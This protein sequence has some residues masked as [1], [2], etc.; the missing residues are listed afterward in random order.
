MNLSKRQ[1]ILYLVI[2]IIISTSLKLYLVDFTIPVNSDNLIYLLQG[3]AHSEGDFALSPKKHP[4]WPLFIAPFYMLI[5]SDSLMDHS[6]TLRLLSLSISTITIILM[7]L[8]GQKF[9][10]EKYSLVA[11]ALF[12]FEPHINR[13]AGFGLAEPIYIVGLISSFYFILTKNSKQVYLSFIIAG[14]VW[15]VRFEGFIL[16]LALSLIYFINF[17]RSSQYLVQ[18]GICVMLFL[19]VVS[20]IFI[21]KYIQYGDIFYFYTGENIFVDDFNMYRTQNLGSDASALDYIQRNG[22]LQFFQKFI[23]NGF[24]NISDSITKLAF[25][26]LIVLLPFGILF[27]LRIFDQEKKYVRA[28]WILVLSILAIFIVP[29]S[30]A[31][32]KRFLLPLLPF[33]IIFATIAIQRVTKYGLSTFYFN[34]K[35]KNIFLVMVLTIILILSITFNVILYEKTDPEEVQEKIKFSKFLIH[36]L[37]GKI[38]DDDNVLEYVAY[39]ILDDDPGIFKSYKIPREKDPQIQFTFASIDLQIIRIY[40][41]NIEN[42]IEEGEKYNLKY[43]AISNKGAAYQF[44]DDVYNNEENYPYF[45]KIFDSRNE[46]YQ[47]YQVSVYE[48]DYKKFHQ[49]TKR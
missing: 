39:A 28:N 17:K 22:F 25:P 30:N 5:K 19:I 29:F 41:T 10:N 9:F 1:I 36:N 16:F 42:L 8:L 12:A 37:N 46:G 3:V 43:I 44:L 11:A 2:I 4:G 45:V 35:H 15:W 32:D 47:K 23:L 13:N 14:L 48:I 33:L 38:L 21:Q 40:G 24:Y 49:T 31:P 18:Y 20:P 6:N 34:E 26:Y 7:Y 27:S